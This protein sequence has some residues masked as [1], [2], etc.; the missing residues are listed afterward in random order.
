MKIKTI[1]VPIYDKVIVGTKEKKIYISLNGQEYDSQYE[2]EKN[3]K[4]FTYNKIRDSIKKK[5]ISPPY[6]C[7]GENIYP[8][9]WYCPS[10]IEEVEWIN[11]QDGAMFNKNHIGKWISSNYDETGR[12][13]VN[14]FE[15]EDV[16]K[17]I[18]EYYLE[19]LELKRQTI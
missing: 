19:I 12:G 15:L 7:E 11:K 17:E 10:S 3:D 5:D 18:K 8:G 13:H 1:E 16:L 4:L 2:C 9:R 14:M 6:S